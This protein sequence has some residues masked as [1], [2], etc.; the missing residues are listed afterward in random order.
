M[1]A[2]AAE[3]SA[4]DEGNTQ[5]EILAAA[6]KAEQLWKAVEVNVFLLLSDGSSALKI[7]FHSIYNL[8][9]WRSSPAKVEGGH[10]GG[11]DSC[12]APP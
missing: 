12:K 7:I 8:S 6:R 2:E 10:R 4:G 11:G 5:A 1:A 3:E 9:G